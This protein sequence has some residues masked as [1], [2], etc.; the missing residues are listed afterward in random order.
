MITWQIGIPTVPHRHP[1]LCRLLEVLDAQMQPGVFVVL[2][3]DNMQASYPVKCQA[4]TDVATA[5]YV[6]IMSDDD[7]VCPD[8]LPR[9]MT[10]LEA[11]PDQV[12]FRVRY[13]EAGVL[14]AQVIH[15][16]R[17]G[18]WYEDGTGF[19]RDICHFNPVRRELVQQVKFR[20]LVCDVEFAADLRALGIIQTEEFIDDEI[21]YYQRDIADNFHSLSQCAPVP[22]QDILPL[23]SYPWLSSL[24]ESR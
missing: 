16:L 13:T 23:P 17:C 21:F 15:S 6:S 4:L 9:V 1:K 2:Y 3:R 10:A 5:E 20:G 8:Y 11:R 22:E 12:G 18:G 24:A 19:Y 14:Q 7:L